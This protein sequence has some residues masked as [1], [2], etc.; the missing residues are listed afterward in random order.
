MNTQ[1]NATKRSALW[2]TA[3]FVSA[4]T[5]ANAAAQENASI[6]T[7]R[8]AQRVLAR[9]VEAAGGPEAL[10]RFRR[11]EIELESQ[12]A[13]GLGQGLRPGAG[14]E[15]GQSNRATVHIAGDR[16]AYQTFNGENLNFRYVPGDG[17][18][19]AH[20]AGTNTIATVEPIAAVN[21]LNRVTVTPMLLLEFSERQPALRSL[22][23][24]ESGSMRFDVVAYAD[25]MGQQRTLYFDA[26]TG[27][28][29][30]S[31]TVTNH[32]QFGDV[33]VSVFY[34]DYRE[35]EGVQLAHRMVLHQGEMVTAETVVQSANLATTIDDTLFERPDSATD[36]PPITAPP[37]GERSLEIEELAE[38]I[39]LVPNAAPNYNAM[40]VMYDDGILVLETPQSPQTSH[41]VIHAISERYPSPPV[42]WA[43]PTHHHFDHSG[44]LFGYIRHGTTI[45]TT[46]GNEEFVRGVAAAPRT[47]GKSGHHAMGMRELRIETFSGR[48]SFGDGARRVELIDVGPNPHADEILVAYIPNIKT[49]M[50]ADLFGF[51]GNVVAANANALA[52]ADRLE[53]LDLDIE[54]FIPVHGQRATAAQF[55]EAVRLGR[56]QQN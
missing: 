4:C 42:R 29:T 9:A 19:W 24:Q 21:F 18:D 39:Y 43:V 23:M 51:N 14:A 11:V 16:L 49:L 32:A 8:E 38:G 52:F 33:T 37:T 2:A 22:G 34:T 3:L 26:A 13:A 20:F 1:P 46:E 5:V 31:E 12:I 15:L 36:G 48:R 41:D 55:W 28:L 56:E 35:V 44:G 47:I 10:G 54:T 6:R 53:Q 7:Q 50:V 40:F 45:V 17:E 25:R 30:R 27:H